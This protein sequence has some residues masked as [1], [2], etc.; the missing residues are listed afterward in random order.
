M[1]Q[2]EKTGTFVPMIVHDPD[3]GGNS[4]YPTVP[5]DVGNLVL[6]CRRLNARILERLAK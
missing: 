2:M 5:E 3:V 4:I 1:E 6:F